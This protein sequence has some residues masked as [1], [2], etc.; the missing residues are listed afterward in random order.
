MFIG[1]FSLLPDSYTYNII[2]QAH[3]T[4][5]WLDDCISTVSGESIISNVYTGI[6]DDIVMTEKCRTGPGLEP[7]VFRLTYERSTS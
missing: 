3:R 5:S 1:K 2:S 4:T 7:R 6:V